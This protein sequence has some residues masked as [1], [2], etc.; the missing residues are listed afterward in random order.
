MPDTTTDP[1]PGLI[2]FE[3]DRL[4]LRQWRESD[5][6]PFAALNADPQGRLYFP[7]CMSREASDVMANRCRDLIATRGWGFWVVER[8]AD[9]ASDAVFLGMVG[10]GIPA[11]NL[12]FMPCVEVG[13]RLARAHWGQGY[14]TEAA[15]GALQIGF[16]RL[17]LAEIVAFTTLTNHPSQA[18]M[19]RLGMARDEAGD[20]DHPALAEG[21]PLRRHCLYRLAREA[22]QAALR[23]G[24]PALRQSAA[25]AHGGAS[26]KPV[27]IAGE[28]E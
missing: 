19:A 24:R 9:A 2:E 23:A 16:E 3:T 27:L 5:L 22:W 10:L 28:N 25:S 17:G 18:V 15:R 20:F 14:A 6:A 8:K 1:V 13:W 11:D 21:H 12:P 7:D 4:R 26:G